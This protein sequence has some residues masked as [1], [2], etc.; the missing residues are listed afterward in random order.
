GFVISREQAQ[1]LGLDRIPG[2]QKHIRP[3]RNGRDLTATPRELWAIDLLGLDIS[4]VRYRYPDVYQWVLERVKPERDQNRRESYRQNWW[5]FGEPR[6]TFRPALENL[7]R[8]IATPMTAKHR[9]FMFLEQEIL[10]D[11]GLI[12]IALDDA[13]YLGVLSSK[14]HV[15]WSLAT[16]G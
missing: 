12:A 6:S 13:Y 7:A 8:Y 14:V 10:P 9:T 4:D 3:I 16:G 2:L 5:I 11:Q 15:D 1:K